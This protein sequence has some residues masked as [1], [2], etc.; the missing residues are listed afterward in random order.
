MKLYTIKRISDGKFFISTDGRGALYFSPSPTFWKTP[1]SIWANLK[2]ICSDYAP[3]KGWMGFPKKDWANFDP[4]KIDLYE[5][6][7][8]EV[9][10]VNVTAIPA[11]EFVQVEKI[12]ELDVAT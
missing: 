12:R 2:R 7:V 11:K 9:D 1:E 6:I 4:E 3:I 5:V 10:L 8:M